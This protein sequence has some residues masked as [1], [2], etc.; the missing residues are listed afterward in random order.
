[1]SFPISPTNGQTTV[2]NGITYTFNSTDNS[3]VRVPV[4]GGIRSTSTSTAPV[5]PSVGDIWYDTV[6][7]D[8]FRYTSDGVTSVWLDITGPTIASTSTGGGGGGSSV[9]AVYDV[10]T[11]STGAFALPVGGTS[12]R[13]ATPVQGYTR[14]NTNTNYLEVFYNANWINMQY[15]GLVSASYTGATIAYSGN[16][17][18]LT[19]TTSGQFVV[20]SAP[21]GATVD[22]LLIGGGGGGA[23]RIGGGGGAGG[24]VTTTSMSVSVGSFSIVVGGAGAAGLTGDGVNPGGNGGN[25]TALGL[26]AYGGGGGGPTDS[27]VGLAGASGGGGGRSGGTAGGAAIYGSQGNSGGTAGPATDRSGGGGGAG[28]TG[29]TGNVSGNGGNGLPNPIPGST[30]GVLSSSTYY[31]AGGGGGSGYGGP[32]GGSGGLGGG[33]SG[34]TTPSASTG[35]NGTANSGGGGGGGGYNAGGTAGGAGGSGVVVIRYKFQ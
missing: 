26:T 6:T 13:P 34:L 14:I 29:A 27:Y 4:I 17:A 25:T 3:W 23:G 24:F 31:L 16:Y 18:L 35:G 11:T 20:T 32:V 12:Q 1:M 5:N 19:Y 2:L 21:V 9:A 15:L 33:G 7:D 22:L 8:I 28:G 10:A 30:A